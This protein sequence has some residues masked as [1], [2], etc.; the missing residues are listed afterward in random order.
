MLLRRFA[1]LSA[2][3]VLLASVT[4]LF[5]Q[6]VAQP[7]DDG[8]FDQSKVQPSDEKGDE[9]IEQRAQ[10]PVHE[11]FASPTTSVAPKAH[12][13]VP[14]TPPAIVEEMPPD[15]KPAGDNVQWLTGY[16][17]FDE[18][19]KDYMWVSGLW[20]QIPPGMD[21][22]PG[23]WNTVTGGYQWSS[24]F[25]KS[26]QVGDLTVV[27]TPPEPLNATDG[28]APNADSSYVP[29]CWVY[30]DKRYVWRPSYW[31]PCRVG[32]VWVPA[33]YVWSPCGYY[34]VDGYW[35]YTLRDRGLLFC[36]VVIQRNYYQRPG[37]V[38]RP[39]YVVHDN[40][41]LS[42]LFIDVRFGCYHFGDYYDKAYAQR[43]Y[44]AWSSYRVNRMH[45][46]SM[47][48]HYRFVHRGNPVWE[49][50][51]ISL[52]GQRVRNEATRPPITLVLQNKFIINQ[53]FNANQAK[54][55]V[56]LAPLS[57]VNPKAVQLVKLNA[58]HLQDQ[59]KFAKKL[60][61]A[62]ANRATFESGIVKSG[63]LPKV[64]DEV[65]SFA[66]SVP[67][68]HALPSVDR[69]LTLPPPPSGGKH[70][71]D[72][73][74]L[75]G[76]VKG[77]TKDKVVLP[78]DKVVLP[79]DKVVLPKDKVVLP[80]DKVIVPKDKV[81]LPKDKV[82]VPKDKGGIPSPK[83]KG[84]PKKSVR[85]D[86]PVAPCRVACLVMSATIGEASTPKYRYAHNGA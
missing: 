52:T 70:Q 23:A 67:K 46:D 20:R 80:K 10:G 8:I 83:D 79:K 59:Q 78:K 50:D 32:W 9:G 84:E 17:H 14:K 35:D 27:P 29:G 60:N 33:R 61:E 22:V 48:D 72:P 36:P 1:M 63:K 31:M 69:L 77:D 39:R 42:C 66:L 26:A 65:K 4:L 13:L 16:W 24:G 6:T 47:Y 49:R 19:G 58:V 71:V 76:L 21:W 30:R 12:P 15:Q 85:V 75:G 54:N 57:K 34:F 38:Y 40:C 18:Q 53:K 5:S 44:V 51:L 64:G 86:E 43:G 45:R 41:L 11:A 73:K 68:N 81:V 28:P 2:G 82:I 55:V 62:S 56:L 3:L 74:V 25:W 37:F 7:L